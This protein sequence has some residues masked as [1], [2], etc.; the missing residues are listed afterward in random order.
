MTREELSEVPDDGVL[1][2]GYYPPPEYGNKPIGCGYYNKS[3]P[4][5]AETEG[6][7]GVY[8]YKNVKKGTFVWAIS[9]QKNPRCAALISLV[10]ADTTDN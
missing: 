5:F 1:M 7:K 10:P 8:Y 2:V 6:H 4:C 9:S 3:E